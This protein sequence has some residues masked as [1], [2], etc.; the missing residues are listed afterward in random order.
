MGRIFRNVQFEA[1]APGT[2]AS[3]RLGPSYANVTTGG[4]TFKLYSLHVVEGQSRYQGH[5]R[6]ALHM[7]DLVC[8]QAQLGN[9]AL[10]INI[11]RKEVARQVSVTDPPGTSPKAPQI[12]LPS[13]TGPTATWVAQADGNDI[14]PS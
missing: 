6:G 10:G 3:V 11:H 13:G 7:E 9:A 14:T 2:L 12:Y 4:N 5:E 1:G 8:T